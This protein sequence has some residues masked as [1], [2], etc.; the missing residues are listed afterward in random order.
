MVSDA[1]FDADDYGPGRSTRQRH[2]P[3]MAVNN[4]GKWFVIFRLNR[5]PADYAHRLKWVGPIYAP[6]GLQGEVLGEGAVLTVCGIKGRPGALEE[7][8]TVNPCPKCWAAK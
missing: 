6:V 1:L 2:A 5:A 8:A 4:D 3:P 7:G